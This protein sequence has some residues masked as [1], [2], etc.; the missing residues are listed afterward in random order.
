LQLARPEKIEV[1]THEND[2]VGLLS[3]GYTLLIEAAWM[4]KN[5]PEYGGDDSEYPKE[6]PWDPCGKLFS[7]DKSVLYSYSFAHF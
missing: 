6:L 3:A 2:K 5:A 4:D 1:P 7:C